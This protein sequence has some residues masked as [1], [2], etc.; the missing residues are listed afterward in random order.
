MGCALTSLV[1]A[2]LAGADLVDCCSSSSSSVSVSGKGSAMAG[3]ASKKSQGSS[4]F[5]V[6]EVV[7]K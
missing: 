2:G 6:F 3:A 4:S 5:L 7:P 1:P